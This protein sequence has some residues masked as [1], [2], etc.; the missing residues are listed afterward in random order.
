M[1]RIKKVAITSSPLDHKDGQKDDQKDDSDE[2][3]SLVTVCSKSTMIKQ[4]SRDLAFLNKIAYSIFGP[5][6]VKP[7][8][9]VS[10]TIPQLE[11]I[12]QQMQHHRKG[13][14]VLDL[15]FLF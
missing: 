11:Q 12:K 6:L 3:S 14:I 13:N 8:R 15:L 5:Q 10:L 1:L 7:G 4:C 2:T 9:L